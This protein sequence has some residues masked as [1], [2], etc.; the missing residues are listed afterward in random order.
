MAA[1]GAGRV[2]FTALPLTASRKGNGSGQNF[3]SAL[4]PAMNV[5]SGA[6]S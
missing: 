5:L 6:G 4:T 1:E 3:S 2:D